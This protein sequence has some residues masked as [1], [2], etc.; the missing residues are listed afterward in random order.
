MQALKAMIQGIWR[1]KKEQ[2]LNPK[3]K[4]LTK[5]IESTFKKEAKGATQHI[6]W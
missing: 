6:F 4:H 1:G 5:V 2:S 3:Y